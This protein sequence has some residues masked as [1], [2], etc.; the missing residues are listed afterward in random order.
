MEVGIFAI[1]KTFELLYK[2][3]NMA[4]TNDP[5]FTKNK[6]DNKYFLNTD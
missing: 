1:K 5:Y 4:E 3:K 2:Y 6:I